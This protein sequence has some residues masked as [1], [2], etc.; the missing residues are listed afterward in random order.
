MNVFSLGSDS[1]E[2]EALLQVS[3]N[4]SKETNNIKELG[5]REFDF[6][7]FLTGTNFDLL[8]HLDQ[9]VQPF[10]HKENTP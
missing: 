7:S 6:Q 3:E 1:E 9:V 4:F 10:N 5:T 2:D 8:Q